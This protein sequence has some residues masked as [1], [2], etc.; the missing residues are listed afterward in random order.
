MPIIFTTALDAEMRAHAQRDYPHECCGFLIGKPGAEGVAVHEVR[1]ADNTRQDS[2]RN[3][4]EIDPGELMRVDKAARAAGLSVVGFYHSHPDA[5]A[6][7]SEFDREHAWQGYCY[8]IV[9]VLSG[10][11]AEMNN[12]L[13]LD[14][15]SGYTQDAVRIV[16]SEN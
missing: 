13:L 4:F 12:W 6:S 16:N 5:P 2:P 7:P 3:R 14:D 9:S 15:H 8:I 11:P 1:A 10:Q